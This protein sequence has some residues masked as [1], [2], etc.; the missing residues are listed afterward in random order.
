MYVYDSGVTTQTSTRNHEMKKVLVTGGAGYIGSACSEYLLNLGYDVTIFD[1][2]LT[3]HREAVDPRAKFILGNLSDRERSRA[4][5][6]RANSTRSCT[7][8][9]FRWSANR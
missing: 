2:L 7:S 6:A 1:G 5:A 9:R 4:S 8:R 3:G